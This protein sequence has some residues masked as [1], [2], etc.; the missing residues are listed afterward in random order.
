MARPDEPSC[1]PASPDV[2]AGCIRVGDD[3][4]FSL[5]SVFFVSENPLFGV[6]G[7]GIEPYKCC[8]IPA[9]DVDKPMIEYTFKILCGC[10]NTAQ[11][12][13]RQSI[14]EGV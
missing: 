9:G 3:C 5:V 10:P 6:G 13:R 1:D 4:P 14:V 12:L 11:H 8:P 2:Q 7:S